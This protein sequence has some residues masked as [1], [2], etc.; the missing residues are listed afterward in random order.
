MTPLSHFQL[1]VDGLIGAN[2]QHVI[3]GLE[4]RQRLALVIAHNPKMVGGHAQEIQRNC[5]TVMVGTAEKVESSCDIN[6][7]N[8]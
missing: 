2:G 1:M 7:S 6:S 4:R 3:D 5:G 8:S